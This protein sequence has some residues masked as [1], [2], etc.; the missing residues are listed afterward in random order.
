MTQLPALAIILGMAKIAR[1]NYL[2]PP[3][4]MLTPKGAQ[5]TTLDKKVP[6]LGAKRSEVI[7]N[8][9]IEL[10]DLNWRF[11]WD[12]GDGHY[13]DFE[14][15]IKLYEDS[16]YEHLVDAKN[17]SDYSERKIDYLARKASDV[18]DTTPKNSESKLN[19]YI[20]STPALHLQDISIR[21]VMAK[22][23]MKFRGE[24]PIKIRSRYNT[25][26]VGISLS[27]KKVSFIKPQIVK[28]PPEKQNQIPSIEDFWQYNRVLQFCDNL[29][30][31]KPEEKKSF[32]KNPE[33]PAVSIST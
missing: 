16:Y 22:L 28:M 4:R 20:Q 9:N 11:A 29:S 2:E 7:R 18:F 24:K 23:G 25:D 33:Y 3:Y 14:E 32:V 15:A 21:R 27:P 1:V 5:W 26:P 12:L 6:R 13:G 31:M 19:Y 17:P 8:L 10:G 30:R